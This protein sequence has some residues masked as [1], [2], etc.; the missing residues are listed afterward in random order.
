MLNH[1]QLFVTPWAIAQQVALSMGFSK[2]EYLSELP[3]PPPRNLPGLGIE[4]MFF[5]AKIRTRAR[6]HLWDS[7]KKYHNPRI[8]AAKEDVTYEEGGRGLL[9]CFHIKILTQMKMK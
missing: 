8:T 1:I 9:L 4:P 6:V 5:W 3:F 2:Q 7:S